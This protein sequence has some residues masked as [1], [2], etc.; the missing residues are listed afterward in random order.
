MRLSYLQIELTGSCKNACLLCLPAQLKTGVNMSLGEARLIA[1]HLYPITHGDARSWLERASGLPHPVKITFAGYGNPVEHPEYESLVRI[2]SDMGL[3][4]TVTCRVQDLNR[5]GPV[6][7]VNVSIA[8]FEDAEI[9]IKHMNGIVFEKIVPHVVLASS[10]DVRLADMFEGVCLLAGNISFFEKISVAGAVILC[11]EH[12]KQVA[13]ANNR[14][15]GYW[16]ALR[17]YLA[18][19]SQFVRDRV[20][21]WGQEPRM[22][23]CAWRRGGLLVN[24]KLRVLPCCNLPC[25]K[26]LGDLHNMDLAT[27]LKG[28]LHDAYFE[29]CAKCPSVVTS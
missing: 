8:S 28:S 12:A 26:P 19:Q 29:H 5:V 1:K 22:K 21:L 6:D 2:F 27:L 9:L 17:E 4:T 25:V 3:E 23:K 7:R 16:L 20:F 11:Q 24:A 15:T 18:K 14:A 13:Q 10:S